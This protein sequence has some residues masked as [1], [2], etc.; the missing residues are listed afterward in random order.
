MD[1]AS[2]RSI[3]FRTSRALNRAGPANP[4]RHAKLIVFAKFENFSQ[5]HLRNRGDDHSLDA[6][7]VGSASPSIYGEDPADAFDSNL[8]LSPL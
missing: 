3:R 1:G 7:A 8:Q 2:S 4:L 5:V 6:A